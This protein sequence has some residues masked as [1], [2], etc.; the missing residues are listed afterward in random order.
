MTILTDSQVFPGHCPMECRIGEGNS[1]N[2]RPRTMAAGMTLSKTC[3]VE[4]VNLGESPLQVS[5]VAFAALIRG[6]AVS[7]AVSGPP[8]IRM[9]AGAAYGRGLIVGFAA[10]EERAAGCSQEE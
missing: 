2:D 6:L 4:T 10:G 3:L 8:V 5:A 9:A 1:V 7:H